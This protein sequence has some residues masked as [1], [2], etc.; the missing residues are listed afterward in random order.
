MRQLRPV[1]E[2]MTF[3]FQCLPQGKGDGFRFIGHR[4][5]RLAAQDL[6]FTP[7]SRF[8]VRA[9]PPTRP[10]RRPR[11]SPDGRG[12]FQILQQKI[13][14]AKKGTAHGESPIPRSFALDARACRW[15]PHE[16]RRLPPIGDDSAIGARRWTKSVTSGANRWPGNRQTACQQIGGR[17]FC[18]RHCLLILFRWRNYPLEGVL[19]C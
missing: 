5:V 6:H 17:E 10:G 9:C 18:H 8:R 7:I 14:G 4:Q 19:F 1:S 15:R 11:G 12:I 16:V 2:T 3:N 13:T